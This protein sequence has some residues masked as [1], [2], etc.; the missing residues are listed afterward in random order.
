MKRIALIFSM[1]VS[2]SAFAQTYNY[3]PVGLTCGPAAPP[4]YCGIAVNADGDGSTATVNFNWA[5]TPA[6]GRSQPLQS[7]WLSQYEGFPIYSAQT[8][9]ALWQSA[10]PNGNTCTGTITNNGDPTYPFVFDAACN[11]TFTDSTVHNVVVHKL[12]GKVYK[13]GGRAT[14]WKWVIGGGSI[15]IS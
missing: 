4:E 9:N 3:Y 8:N 13:V 10:Y 11:M 14:G 1:L 2:G 15:V 7:V 6:V 12:L 5:T